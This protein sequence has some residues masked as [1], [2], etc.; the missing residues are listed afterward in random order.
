MAPSCDHENGTCAH[1]HL[2]SAK[3]YPNARPPS[4]SSMSRT[5]RDYERMQR[6]LDELE[7]L[8]IPL[9]PV[10]EQSDYGT[11]EAENRMN[12]TPSPNQKQYY[13]WNPDYEARRQARKRLWSP[14]LTPDPDGPHRPLY[15]LQPSQRPPSPSS[16]RRRQ[17]RS[18][19]RQPIAQAST[20]T[21][22]KFRLQL[23]QKAQCKVRK[24]QKAATPRRPITRSMKALNEVALA[25]RRGYVSILSDRGG[26]RVARFGEFM[27]GI[28]KGS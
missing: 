6:R 21:L 3:I 26:S 4:P 5:C 20:Q 19:L 22:D 16:N 13:Y 28:S 7:A 23:P 9:P 25:N 14:P 27:D 17:R 15:S 1:T 11:E 10:E 2:W 12:N 18:S 24:P 8:E